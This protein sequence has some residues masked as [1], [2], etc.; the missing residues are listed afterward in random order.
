MGLIELFK[1]WFNVGSGYQARHQSNYTIIEN[2]LN[3]LFGRVDGISTTVGAQ[4]VLQ[5]SLLWDR[6]GLIGLD[7]Y[8]FDEGVLAGPGYNLTVDPGGYTLGDGTIRQNSAP[9]QVSMAGVATGTYYL[10][11]DQS[12]VPTVS[13]SSTT[14]GTR[15][16]HWDAATHTVA[17]KTIVV[18]VSILLDGDD[19]QAM[20]YSAA[21]TT[22]Y[23]KVGDRLND[24]EHG[25]DPW[26]SYYAQN[27]PHNGLNFKYK[28]GKVR[29]D[30]VVTDTAAGQVT[31]ANG[32]PNYLE[33]DPATG[34]VS[35]NQLGF[36]SGK[37]P[38]YA[39]VTA[40]GAITVITD[41][42]TSAIAGTGGGGGGGHTQGTDQGTTASEF[43][44]DSD[45]IGSPT[46]RVG[47][48]VE[49]GNNPKAKM[50]FNRD[51]D[52]WQWTTDGGVTWHDI[53]DPAL[54]LGSQEFSKIIMIDVPPAV[55]ALPNQIQS[56][57]WIELDLS[58][59]L[60]E[61][62]MG[63]KSVTLAVFLNGM[64]DDGSSFM[65]FKKNGVEGDPGLGMAAFPAAVNAVVERN[66]IQVEPDANGKIAYY[67]STSGT[68]TLA[69]VYLL[70]Y[71]AK[72][73]GVGTQV[74]SITTDAIEVGAGITM[75]REI[76]GWFNRGLV[77]RLAVS[78]V[79]G[80]PYDVSVFGRST[81]VEAD[82]MYKAEG[83]LASPDYVDLEPFWYQD[84]SGDAKLYLQIEN[85][86]AEGG[87]VVV[88]AD[89]EQFA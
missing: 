5:I 45:A 77:H 81:Y 76:T 11:V 3:T 52:A 84:K 60:T 10:N 33:L 88:A 64:P 82:L 12:G 73:A 23:Q 24:L 27:L 14:N 32:V 25:I 75:T 53:E 55:L 54:R 46:G 18:G 69:V 72:V 83:I 36:T 78:P 86:G 67:L 37:I 7:S 59:F 4:G 8:D 6:R 30:S 29:N 40:G 17:N 80:G 13:A 34:A 1:D 38:L 19:Y 56:E 21:K 79:G 39:A 87:S 41:L 16:F 15:S 26:G 65:A 71:V 58:A 9:V 48:T 47:L 89:A 35:A 42:R 66:I 31:L 2:A 74:R 49:N 57:D 44:L 51:T 62:P 50:Q 70:N 22:Q 20:L 43:T 61:A 85:K 28:A 63:C 68:V